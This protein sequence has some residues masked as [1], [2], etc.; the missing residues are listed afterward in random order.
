MAIHCE[1]S[2]KKITDKQFKP[3]VTPTAIGN[4]RNSSN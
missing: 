2:V 4:G 1:K 3:T